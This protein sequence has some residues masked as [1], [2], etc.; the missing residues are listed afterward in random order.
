MVIL[1]DVVCG[2]HMSLILIF[3]SQ[4]ISNGNVFNYKVLDLFEHCKF[5]VEHL[6]PRSIEKYKK[7]NFIIREVRTYICT[8]KWF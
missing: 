6:H 8:S 7:I 3:V 1:A 2:P 5:G 4:A